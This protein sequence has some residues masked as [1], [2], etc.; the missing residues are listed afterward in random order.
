LTER[1]PSRLKPL[2]PRYPS[3]NQ[4]PG[5]HFPPPRNRPFFQP[6]SDPCSYL[7]LHPCLRVHTPTLPT[8][9]VG[10]IFPLNRI[11][12][13]HSFD[14]IVMRFNL[15]LLC[16]R[17]GKVTFPSPRADKTGLLIPEWC[18]LPPPAGSLTPTVPIL[19]IWF[20]HALAT[21]CLGRHTPTRYPDALNKTGWTPFPPFSFLGFSPG[22]FPSSFLFPSQ[23]E[24]LTPHNRLF[25]LHALM[26][27]CRST[28]VSDRKRFYSLKKSLATPPKRLEK[29]VEHS[30]FVPPHST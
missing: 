8:R 9:H 30:L 15:P 10:S 5:F 29:C 7:I 25:G 1:S 24:S 6:I 14:C 2:S 27:S 21:T 4:C 28:F 23:N 19:G 13:L 12:G 17:R 26:M 3:F 20:F 16:S 18:A 11:S 22:L